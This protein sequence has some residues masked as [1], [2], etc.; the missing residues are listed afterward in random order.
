MNQNI[1]PL[2]SSGPSENYKT[3]Y[4]IGLEIRRRGKDLSI[5]LDD[6]APGNPKEIRI[7]SLSW[8][9]SPT[10][11]ELQKGIAELLEGKG[12]DTD[13]KN[14]GS[15]G[16]SSLPTALSMNFSENCYILFNL[17]KHFDNV[18][19]SKD[20]A[21]FQREKVSSGANPI[22]WGK[23]VTGISDGVAKLEDDGAGAGA[24]C[25]AA[26]FAYSR[27]E[28]TDKSSIVRFNLYLDIVAGDPASDTDPYIPIIVD[29]D[30]RFP[31][32]NGP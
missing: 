1:E 7:K 22:A 23:R 31:G 18:R 10:D 20:V 16:Q 8:Q 11:E 24:G 3:I 26:L 19:F 4:L 30:V 29:P 5:T 28:L 17:G 21:A 15:G 12:K 13:L 25:T 9:S 32:G 27:E 14:Q 6:D 2:P